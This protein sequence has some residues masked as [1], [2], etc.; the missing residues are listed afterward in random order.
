MN[1]TFSLSIAVVMLLLAAASASKTD[2]SPAL[3]REGK[4]PEAIII[5]GG[6]IITME[7]AEPV[8]E[9]VVVSGKKI[10]F[11]GNLQEAQQ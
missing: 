8:A 1:S 6:E 10:A 9:A 7:M 11:V 5:S 4:K 3:E 2:S